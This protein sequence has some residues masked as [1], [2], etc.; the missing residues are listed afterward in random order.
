MTTIPSTQLIHGASMPALGLG[1][2][3]MNDDEAANA[4]RAA[5]ERG[6]RHFDTAENYRNEAGVGRGVRECGLAREELFVTSKFNR[7]WHSVEGVR[8]AWRASTERMGL[9][10]IDLLLIHWPN[11]DQ[12]RY[13]DAFRGLLELL[14]DGSVR[15]IG[16][17][18]FKPSHLQ[19][20]V[21]ETG[22]VPDVNQIQLSP[23]T[24]R[25]DS[26]AA[27][28]EHGVITESWS[29]IKAEGLLTDPVVL[30]IAE[31]VGRTPAQTVLRWHVQQGL[32]PLPKTSTPER[33][34][35]NAAIFDFALDD[36]QLAALSALDK[37]HRAA[38]D[39]DTFGH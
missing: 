27:N 37:G 26:V 25:R 22:E 30:E 34:V 31:Q 38:E 11:P 21:D 10:H 29:P 36:Q 23:Y 3:P 5:V 2:Y 19:R 32:V 33:M 7:E 13:V 24:T 20:I 8:K 35:E 12:D 16:V 39:S 14:A 4:V 6:Y 15:A 28:I 17:S 1:T 18:N 9:D